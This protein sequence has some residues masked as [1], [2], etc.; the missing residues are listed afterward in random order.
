MEERF[1][2]WDGISIVCL[3]LAIIFFLLVLI[4]APFTVR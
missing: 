4:T 1:G 2:L 3:P